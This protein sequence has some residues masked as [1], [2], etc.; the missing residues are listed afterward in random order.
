[1]YLSGKNIHATTD[2]MRA[3]YE[4]LDAHAAMQS[5]KQNAGGQ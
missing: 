4:F 5:G 2:A 3:R 1:M